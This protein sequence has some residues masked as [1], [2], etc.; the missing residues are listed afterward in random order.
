MDCIHLK[1]EYL[2][3]AVR[4]VLGNEPQPYGCE[5]LRLCFDKDVEEDRIEKRDW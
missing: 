3:S 4:C 2:S 5:S 1:R